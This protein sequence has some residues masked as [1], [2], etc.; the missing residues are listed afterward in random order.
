MKTHLPREVTNV[1]A[2][3]GNVEWRLSYL[4]TGLPSYTSSPALRLDCWQFTLE[5]RR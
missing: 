4:C 1:H 5:M 2:L 3:I